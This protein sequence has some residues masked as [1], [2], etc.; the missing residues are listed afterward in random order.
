[1]SSRIADQSAG[2]FSETPRPGDDRRLPTRLLGGEH[3]FIEGDY[4]QASCIPSSVLE[5]ARN[6]Q[7]G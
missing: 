3:A 4:Q 7:R 1:V 5:H 2:S 6:C